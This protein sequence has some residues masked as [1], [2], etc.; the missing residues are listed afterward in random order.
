M[1]KY[2]TILLDDTSVSFCHADN[3]YQ[4]CNLIPI[5]TLKEGIKFAMKENLS[6]QFVYPNYDLPIEYIKV[7]NTIDHIDI[8]SAAYSL[9]ADIV[10]IDGYEKIDTYIRQA[11]LDSTF[12]LRCN[13]NELLASERTISEAIKVLHRINI[14]IKDIETFSDLDIDSYRIFLNKLSNTVSNEYLEG[15]N[16]Q[17]N[18]LTDRLFL[19]N[20]NYCNAGVESIT[21]S[22]NGNFYICP[23]FYYDEYTNKQQT[24]PIGNIDRGVNIKNSQLLKVNYAPICRICDAYHCKRCVWLNKKMTRE[25]NTPSRQQCVM[26]HIERNAGRFIKDKIEKSKFD[27][28]CDIPEIDYLDPFDIL[29]Q[30]K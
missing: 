8:K 9:S 2:L 27:N 22:P 5:N 26:A 12:I 21:L 6:I 10:V 24:S 20:P 30:K 29:T 28:I 11:N 16:P 25:V 3:P 1:I 4:T 23:A 14:I 19:E 13:F 18:I 17:L 7:I 15:H